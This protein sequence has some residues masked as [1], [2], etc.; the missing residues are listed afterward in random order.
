MKSKLVSHLSGLPYCVSDRLM[1][2]RIQFFSDRFAAIISVYAPTLL[3]SGAG[4]KSFYSDLRDIPRKLNKDDK[5]VL[6]GD[7]NAR[8]GCD[9]AAWNFLR[10]HSTR[11]CNSKDLF[12]MQLCQ[13][14][15]LTLTNTWL[16]QPDKYKAIWKHPLPGQWHILD[17]VAVR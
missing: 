2:L 16:R 12:L 6:M 9:H 4:I 15:D 3:T 5:I 10:R 17:Y 1:T 14:I 7:F 13:K 8:L 11:E